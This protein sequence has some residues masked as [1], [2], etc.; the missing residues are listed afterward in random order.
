MY[1]DNE[2]VRY[3][4]SGDVFHYRWAARRCL[5]MLHPKS[6]VKRIVIEGSKENTLAAEYVIDVAE[7][8]EEVEGN[9]KQISYFQLKH[10]T[11]R[12][13]VP[14]TLS[15]LKDT[16]EGFAKRFSAL[17]YNN[18]I[19]QIDAVRFSIITNRQIA[20]SLKTGIAAIKNGENAEPKFQTTLEKYIQLKDEKL[21]EFCASLELSDGEGGYIAQKHEL[22]AEISKLLAGAVDNAQIDSVIA[23]V[24]DKA[25]PDN[26]GE[27]IREDILKRFGV[28]AERDLFPAPLELEKFKNFIKREQHKIL[29]S[30]VLEAS[31]PVILHA[32]GGVGKSVFSQQLA[33]SLPT[34]SLR[35]VYDCFG[36]GKY[37]NRSE[38]RHR[39]RDALVQIAN[40][41][42]LHGLCEI[43]LPRS[44][45]L[46]DAILRAFLSRLKTAATAIK[47]VDKDAALAIL[48]DV[49]DNAEM[50]AK[51]FSEY[52]FAHQLLREEVPAGCRIVTLCRT[53]RIDLLKPLSTVR[54]ME[55]KPF[56]Q[57]ETVVHLRDHFP[58]AT[59][60]DGLEF[61][62][63]TGG[64]PRVQANALSIHQNTVSDVLAGLGLSGTTVEEQIAA[65]LES[66]ISTIKDK[67]PTNFQRPINAICLGLANLTPFIPINVLA[68]AAEVEVSTV[69]SF[70][71]DLGR[72]LLISEKSVQFRDEPTETWFRDRFSA[73]K[74][75][76]ESYIMSLKP[77]ASEFSYVAQVLP[78][79]LLQSENY[80][81]LIGL[82][83]SDDYLPEDSPI[84]ERNIRVYRLQFA[85]KAV[86][87]QK[88]YADAA[89]LALR[90]GEEVAGDKRQLEL[91][92]QNVDLIAPLQSPQRVQ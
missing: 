40:E 42:A 88:R 64:N 1:N 75:Q 87:K 3:S 89:K 15:G 48:I 4:R 33:E 8:T 11:Q 61:Y 45:D 19:H 28:T 76:I 26:K 90:A 62:R 51:E 82:A 32:G 21:R 10:T 70:V 81:D 17:G 55:L 22:Q 72:P 30:S 25:L 39:H 69:V 52:Y 65:Q 49:A 13:D 84:D 37:R 20:D 12:V 29:L 63:L 68:T 73:S 91:L 44:T 77:L 14:F 27:I 7:Y 79:L 80:N 66:A 86:L 24:Q 67:L 74:Q 83:L 43:L 38:S 59:D 31:T 23:L 46:D 92:T 36:S 47:K 34:G 18:K 16:L 71:A 50:A 57:A 54:Q 2:L 41:I 78:S 6:S 35:I 85:F 9:N 56:S 58:S 60:I 53:E 5:K